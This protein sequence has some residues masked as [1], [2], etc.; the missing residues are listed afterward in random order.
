MNIFT[1]FP[2]LAFNMPE[3]LFNIVNATQNPLIFAEY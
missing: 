2:E 1:D 3:L